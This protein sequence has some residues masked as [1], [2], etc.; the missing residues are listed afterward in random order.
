VVECASAYEDYLAE[1]HKKLREN[2]RRAERTADARGGFA[3]EVVTAEVRWEQV[4]GELLSVYDAAEDASPKQHFLRG[5]LADFTNELLGRAAREDR[6]RLFIGRMDGV[7][8][9]FGI[10][11]W[12]NGV[13]SYWMTRFDPRWR[14]YS[15]GTLILRDVIAY[16][17][18]QGATR[19][20]LMLGEGPHKQRW[21][22]SSYP[23]VSVLA[24]SSRPLLT[25]GRTVLAGAAMAHGRRTPSAA[26][27][28]GR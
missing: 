9:S 23:T 10:A 11:F 27:G 15:T 24:A 5:A 19:V 4:R 7:A 6:L 22:T 21:S 13:L 25:L 8:T 16:G 2:L 17:F 26:G 1:R 12:S 3:V 14:D 28:P 20:D 18:A